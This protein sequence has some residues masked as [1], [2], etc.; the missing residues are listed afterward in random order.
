MTKKLGAPLV[1]SADTL[2]AAEIIISFPLQ[3]I[4]LRGRPN[5]LD[6]ATLDESALRE[7]CEMAWK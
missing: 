5:L 7:V 4:S 3:T 6:V 1:A 2:R